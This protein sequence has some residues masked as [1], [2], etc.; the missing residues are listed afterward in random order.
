VRWPGIRRALPDGQRV[1]HALLDAYGAP[2]AAVSA[3]VLIGTVAALQPL[4]TGRSAVARKRAPRRVALEEAQIQADVRGSV[5]LH[6]DPA[7]ERWRIA[8]SLRSS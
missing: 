5:A 3:D 7:D 8:L 6:A 4:R 2:V 1:R